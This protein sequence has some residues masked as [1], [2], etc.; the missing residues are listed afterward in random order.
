MPPCARLDS[1]GRNARGET[2]PLKFLVH[3]WWIE[4]W[5]LGEICC[6][7]RAGAGA[8]AG[9]TRE[10]SLSLFI[11]N[12]VTGLPPSPRLP[13]DYDQRTA[14][15]DRS[16]VGSGHLGKLVTGLPPVA[17]QRRPSGCLWRYRYVEWRDRDRQ[18]EARGGWGGRG[19]AER[20]EDRH[21]CFLPPPR[22]WTVSS[23]AAPARPGQPNRRRKWPKVGRSPHW[24]GQTALGPRHC[25]RSLRFVF[26]SLSAVSRVTDSTVC[27]RCSCW[28]S[29]SGAAVLRALSGFYGIGR[30]SAFPLWFSCGVVCSVR[31]CLCLA[32][33]PALL[34]C[35]FVRLKIGRYAQLRPQSSHQPITV[36]IFKLY[37]NV[38]M[39]LAR[40]VRK[41]WHMPSGSG[42]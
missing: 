2:Q 29:S 37:F 34:T 16:G 23:R 36:D 39:A 38:R 14:R 22:G 20:S 9:I 30:A 19:I 33:W 18:T 27:V 26:I 24:W 28:Q 8:G 7:R 1:D 13:F 15:A 12:A 11:D 21:S 35:D 17:A 42:Y 40:W 10:M 32:T 6:K 41:P 3:F 5:C 31:W 25:A 4:E